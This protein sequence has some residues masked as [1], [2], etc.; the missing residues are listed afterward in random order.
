MY[1]RVTR[2]AIILEYD[3]FCTHVLHDS[4]YPLFVVL[5]VDCTTHN[6]IYGID[7]GTDT[8]FILITVRFISKY[9]TY[10]RN[11]P[12]I[13][14]PNHARYSVMW[15]NTCTQQLNPHHGIYDVIPAT[16][17]SLV[18]GKLIVYDVCVVHVYDFFN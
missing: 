12:C 17:V 13:I 1:C 7:V 2:N 18:H 16:C 5:T 8:D 3:A 14:T 11:I 10:V 9:Q 6:I 4:K 15:R